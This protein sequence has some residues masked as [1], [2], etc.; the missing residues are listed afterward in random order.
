[1]REL[2]TERLRL[3]PFCADDAS[4][5]VALAGD[6]SVA[7]MTSDIPH[8]LTEADAAPWLRC[9]PGEV[10]YAIEYQGRLIGGVGYFRRP[11]GAGELGFWIGRP[12]WGQGLATEA[13]R[14]VVLYGFTSGGLQAFSSSHFV[15]NVPSR[16]VLL[17]L[18]FESIGQA[19]MWCVARR[20]MV[21]VVEYW[22]TRP[23]EAAVPTR[24]GGGRWRALFG[25]LRRPAESGAAGTVTLRDPARRS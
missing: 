21:D 13:T 3:R 7:R 4:A 6:L 18:G 19:S 22:L 12:W 10:R 1:M 2:Q 11:S 23:A 24:A 15:D 16:R 8:P 14:A 17:K 9:E 25:K 20:S 5:F